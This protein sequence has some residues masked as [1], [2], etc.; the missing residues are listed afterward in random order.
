MVSCQQTLHSRP[1]ASRE[2]NDGKNHQYV[3]PLE[4]QLIL[5]GYCKT[6]CSA[7]TGH[8]KLREPLFARCMGFKNFDLGIHDCH[9]SPD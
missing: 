7:S 4:R 5:E 2:T 9:Q 8:K 3:W 6:H 1:K